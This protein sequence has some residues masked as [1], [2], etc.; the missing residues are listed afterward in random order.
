M[1]EWSESE[2]LEMENEN[3]KFFYFSFALQY[4]QLSKLAAR[5]QD[6]PAS[7]R[8]EEMQKFKGKMKTTFM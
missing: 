4:R 8:G 5:P 1:M 7:E 3:E 6:L 2:Q